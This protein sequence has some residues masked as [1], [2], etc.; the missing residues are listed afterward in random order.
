M[1]NV[2]IVLICLVSPKIVLGQHCLHKNLSKEF[3]FEIL[4]RKIKVPNELIDSNSVKVI[5]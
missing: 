4:V 5:V 2:F 1:K 3:N